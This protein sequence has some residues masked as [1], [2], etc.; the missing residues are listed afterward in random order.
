MPPT[1]NREKETTST[2]TAKQK[3]PCTTE[4]E[5]MKKIQSYISI[6]GSEMNIYMYI[7]VYYNHE[8]DS[9]VHRPNNHNNQ[10]SPPE[11]HNKRNESLNPRGKR[12][13][14]ERT[15]TRIEDTQRNDVGGEYWDSR[16]D[17]IDWMNSDRQELYL[18][19]P[20]PPPLSMIEPHRSPQHRQEEAPREQTSK[21]KRETA[22]NTF[23]VPH[24]MTSTVSLRFLLCFSLFL[25]VGWVFFFFSSFFFLL[26]LFFFVSAFLCVS[27]QTVGWWQRTEVKR[28]SRMVMM[29]ISSRIFFVFMIVG[30]AVASQRAQA[31]NNRPVLGILTEV[32]R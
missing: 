29:S 19:H 1:Q 11:D 17:L 21:Q 7:Q 3:E 12:R 8:A 18:R 4:Y 24:C 23:P 10:D 30:I 6:L 25:S 22:T 15:Q 27:S 14:S 20:Y 9:H 13:A 31:L 32:C 26:L 16:G 5:R 2:Y 28:P